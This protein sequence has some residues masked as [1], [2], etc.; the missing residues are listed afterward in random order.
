[1]GAL[2]TILFFGV[3]DQ[4]TIKPL[5]QFLRNNGLSDYGAITQ[6]EH[7]NNEISKA[8]KNRDKDTNIKVN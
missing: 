5:T 7:I 8:E 1:M 3:N 2:F 6:R 4:I